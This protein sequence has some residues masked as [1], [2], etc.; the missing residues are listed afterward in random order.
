MIEELLVDLVKEDPALELVLEFLFESQGEFISF[1]N[2]MP[3]DKESEVC[4]LQGEQ[5]DD[6]PDCLS[7]GVADDLYQDGTLSFSRLTWTLLWY[8][9]ICISWLLGF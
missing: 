1:L 7:L 9:F 6:S 3:E 8:W 5:E 4:D 2:E